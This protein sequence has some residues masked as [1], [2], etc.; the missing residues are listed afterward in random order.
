MKILVRSIAVIAA[1]VAFTAIAHAQS[2]P[3]Y[4]DVSA[5]T[6]EIADQYFKAYVDRDWDRIEPHLA[7]GAQ[8]DDPTARIIFGGVGHQGKA[9]MM[10]AFREGYASISAMS[11]DPQR[12]L[13]SGEYGIFEG[14]LNWTLE[15]EGMSVASSAPIITIVRVENGL[16]TE[17]YDY[18]DYAPFVTSLKAAR[19][20]AGK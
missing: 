15:L 10:K 17:H 19:A 11:F 16:V 18:V 3:Q 2:R 9:A 5:A 6:A 20:A 4:G 12:V 8:F 7:E 13:H 14:V 1:F